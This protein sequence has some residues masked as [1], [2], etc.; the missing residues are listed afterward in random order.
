[1][2]QK[3]EVHIFS[4]FFFHVLFMFLWNYSKI[5]SLQVTVVSE[6]KSSKKF[7]FGWV[8]HESFL[9][10]H[11]VYLNDLDVCWHQTLHEHVEIEGMNVIVV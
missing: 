7:G 1:M 9:Y 10:E 5:Y 3:Q 11:G 4:V 2:T 8:E 6:P